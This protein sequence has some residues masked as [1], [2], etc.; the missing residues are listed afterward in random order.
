MNEY[1]SSENFKLLETALYLVM[2][3]SVKGSAT[4]GAVDLN[5]FVPLQPL[6]NSHIVPALQHSH[7]VVRVAAIKFITLF[8]TRLP[9]LSEMLPSL[10]TSL[11]DSCSV[12]AT[13]A[14]ICIERICRSNLFEYF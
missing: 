11:T 4:S 3:L 8:R 7:P 9:D 14:S 1:L 13:Y 10:V 12:V 5:E 6:F 2:S